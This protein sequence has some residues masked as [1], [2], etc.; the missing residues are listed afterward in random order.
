[1]RTGSRLR[2]NPFLPVAVALAW[3]VAAMPCGAASLDPASPDLAHPRLDP[4]A[5]AEVVRCEYRVVDGVV[6]QGFDRLVVMNR[7]TMVYTARGAEA[8]GTSSILYGEGTEVD[9]LFVRVTAPDGRSR[10]VTPEK[11]VD[12][13]V[14][15]LGGMRLRRKTFVVPGLVP[16]SLVEVSSRI[17]MLDGW[18]VRDL[19]LPCQDDV[20]IRSL[21]VR[22]RPWKDRPFTL[23]SSVSLVPA[24][25]PT[26]DAEGYRTI[27]VR[28]VPALVEEPWM[29]PF[30]R[31][32]AFLYGEYG[33]PDVAPYSINRLAGRTGEGTDLRKV[34]P[35]PDTLAVIAKS[36][37]G[38]ATGL[39][40]RAER[41]FRH[42]RTGLRNLSFAADS[43]S[44]PLPAAA[45]MADV[46][47][48]QTLHRAEGTALGVNL[49]LAG[50][51]I[52]SGLDTR[53]VLV[54]GEVPYWM[55][56]APSLASVARVLVAVA[57]P[58][59]WLFLDPGDPDQPP[60]LV[61]PSAE[62]VAAWLS[63]G[64]K[65]TDITMPRS[66]ASAS[67]LEREADLVLTPEGDVEGRLHVRWTGH[68]A[69][70]ERRAFAK[71]GAGERAGKALEGLRTRW[72]SAEVDSFEMVIPGDGIEPVEWACRVRLR[73]YAPA[74]GDLLLAPLDPFEELHVE[75][76]ADS[77]RR[78]PVHWDFS[79]SESDRVRIALPAGARVTPP[80]APAAASMAG[81][82][83]SD[84]SV[85]EDAPGRGL[86]FERQAAFTCPAEG[87][88]PAERWPELRAA[89]GASL[90]GS[91]LVAEIAAGASSP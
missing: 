45:T 49:A 20:P 35:V 18:Y 90:A 50:L 38:G 36:I 24:E 89:I 67:R 61:D 78:H 47:P 39:A 71:L 91:R 16:G 79:W 27:V 55:G 42:C 63:G 14:L 77:S 48:L 84:C 60:G 2:G 30:G 31:V 88:L 28:D 11:M 40:E 74:A 46:R 7:A 68:L 23:H 75:V 69:A 72:P 8:H 21:R 5:D 22:V 65:V 10:V 4:A 87:D 73:G 80:R 52:A 13:E 81:R 85:R 34:L 25:P 33:E 3:C 29:P 37:E 57:R 19:F 82:F 6:A 70:Q 56:E 54:S 44:R 59:G 51:A 1:M 76:A 9:N 53:L 64:G 83:E 62:G 66:P 26:T 32:S 41:L 17:R 12:Q 86:V 15:R 58:G 43:A